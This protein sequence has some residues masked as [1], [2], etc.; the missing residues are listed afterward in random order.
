MSIEIHPQFN[1]KCHEVYVGDL[2]LL[3][4]Y[5]TLVGFAVPG[6]G[7]ITSENVWGSTT[8]KHINSFRARYEKIDREVFKK[9]VELLDQ[10]LSGKRTRKGLETQLT[11]LFKGL[12][13]QR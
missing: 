11:K 6:I 3:F 2:T 12:E 9:A 4:S 10:H 7:R 1:G 13:P 8:G 5:E